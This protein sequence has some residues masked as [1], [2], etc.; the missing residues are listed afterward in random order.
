[1]AGRRLLCPHVAFPQRACR[2]TGRE[3]CRGREKE[4]EGREG[5][6]RKRERLVRTPVPS[7]QGPTLVTSFNLNYLDMG[8]ISKYSY[9]VS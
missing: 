2:V 4:G 8:S 6:E 5:G 9:I 1:M 3:R 7:D